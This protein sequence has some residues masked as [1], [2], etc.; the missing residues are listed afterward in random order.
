MYCLIHNISSSDH[1]IDASKFFYHIDLEKKL[2]KREVLTE[3]LVYF[4][5]FFNC[6][7]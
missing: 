3:H 4:W 1:I 5:Y 2:V 7:F 6:F